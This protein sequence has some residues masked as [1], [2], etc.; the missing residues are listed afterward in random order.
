MIISINF[1]RSKLDRECLKWS[2]ILCHKQYFT[3][4]LSE[5]ADFEY[6]KEFLEK[7]IQ[8][9][10]AI[11]NNIETHNIFVDTWLNAYCLGLTILSFENVGEFNSIIKAIC[12]EESLDYD[13]AFDTIDTVVSSAYQ[14][15]IPSMKS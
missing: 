12:E 9:V 11:N 3:N 7:Y 10:N 13:T 2:F 8:Q 5:Y 4:K 14:G 1:W 15:L 6:Q